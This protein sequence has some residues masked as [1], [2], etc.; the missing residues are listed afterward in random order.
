MS[1]RLV[2][3]SALLAGPWLAALACSTPPADPPSSGDAVS[4]SDKKTSGSSSDAGAPLAK[5]GGDAG[6]NAP[7]PSGKGVDGGSDPAPA[8]EAC[9]AEC[10]SSLRAKC[11]G[12]DGFCTSVCGSLTDG[13]LSCLVAAADCSKPTWFGCVP[14][15]PANDGKG[16]K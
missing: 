11:D 5:G 1:Q 14:P 4:T 13:Q 16:G 2:L 9:V 12:D 10:E 15:D 6:P 3:S 8:N 7:V